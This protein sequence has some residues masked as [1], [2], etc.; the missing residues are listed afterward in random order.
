[1]AVSTGTAVGWNGEPPTL[2]PGLD[3]TLDL[4][5]G[6]DLLIL[7][8]ATAY[9]DCFPNH[10]DGLLLLEVD[11]STVVQRVVRTDWDL[12]REQPFGITWLA[13][14]LPPGA[15]QV[16]VLIAYAGG[17]FGGD[18]TLCIGSTDPDERQ[19]RLTVIGF[20]PTP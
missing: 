19:A 3:V 14:A 13:A 17:I 10:N 9:D 12:N 1:M 20:P 7:V 16:R 8:D 11:G 4:P 6:G 2:V 18:P 5:G 15:H